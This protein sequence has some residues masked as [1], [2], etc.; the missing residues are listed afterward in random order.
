M[1]SALV[2][3][4]G[5]NTQLIKLVGF[6]KKGRHTNMSGNYKSSKSIYTFVDS[7]IGADWNRQEVNVISKHAVE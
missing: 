3:F 1:L 2:F 5:K 7:L 6:L 4:F